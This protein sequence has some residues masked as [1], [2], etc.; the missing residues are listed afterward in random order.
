MQS[1][2]DDEEQPV[3]AFEDDPGGEFVHAVLQDGD[4]D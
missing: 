2:F 3:D 1:V 4:E